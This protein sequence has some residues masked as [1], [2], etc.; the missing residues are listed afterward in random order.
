MTQ[1]NNNS[2]DQ[3][4]DPTFRNINRLFVLSLKIGKNDPVK[5]SFDKCYMPLV[6]IKYFNGL[7][8]NKSVLTRQPEANQEHMKNLSKY[9]EMVTIQ[10]E[11]CYIICIIKIIINSLVQI[12]QDKQMRIFVNK[13]ILQENQKN[14][15]LQQCFFIAEKQQKRDKLFLQIHFCNCNRMI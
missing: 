6:E 12:Y 7:I 2:L 3:L 1:S 14:V 10:L 5:N 15:I 4:I 13:L 11:I 9:Q 8:Y